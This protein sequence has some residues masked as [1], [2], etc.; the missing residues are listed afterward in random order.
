MALRRKWQV[1][2]PEISDTGQPRLRC[3]AFINTD[4]P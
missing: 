2:A 4:G 3:S 1:I